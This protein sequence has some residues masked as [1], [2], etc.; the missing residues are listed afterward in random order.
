MRSYV[1][2]PVMLSNIPGS[3]SVYLVAAQHIWIMLDVRTPLLRVYSTGLHALCVV[4]GITDASETIHK[5][6]LYAICVLSGALCGVSAALLHM[7]VRE[8]NVARAVAHAASIVRDAMY[9]KPDSV[10]RNA[11]HVN[12]HVAAH[13]QNAQLWRCVFGGLIVVGTLLQTFLSGK[14][15]LRI[16]EMRKL[17][18]R[19]AIL[20]ALSN[21]RYLFVPY[22]CALATASLSQGQSGTRVSL[23]A[24]SVFEFA[25]AASYLYNIAMDLIAS[26]QIVFAKR[27]YFA[28]VA[29]SVTVPALISDCF[30][31]FAVLDG[32]NGYEMLLF[33][34]VITLWL[35]LFVAQHRHYSLARLFMEVWPNGKLV[36]EDAPSTENAALETC[37]N[38]ADATSVVVRDADARVFTICL[39]DDFNMYNHLHTPAVKGEGAPFGVRVSL[40]GAGLRMFDA[41]FEE[42]ES[43]TRAMIGR[44]FLWR[45]LWG[46]QLAAL[47]VHGSAILLLANL[48][49]SM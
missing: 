18:T 16:T 40:A 31:R 48:F 38:F 30:A 10:A 4:L 25:Q 21:T 46:V 20:P 42:N 39:T 29:C 28:Y 5:C 22:V 27:L 11:A 7:L 14:D 32:V 17:A 9:H 47:A 8:H 26:K 13:N 12:A 37:D 1:C 3:R 41:T 2:L 6:A 43:A 15:A 24:F 36:P 44:L 35:S 45:C 34:T 33:A 23:L 49:Y 19:N